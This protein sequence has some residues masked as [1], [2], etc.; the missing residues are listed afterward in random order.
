MFTAERVQSFDTTGICLYTHQF[1]HFFFHYLL[2]IINLFCERI[3]GRQVRIG[4]VNI[5]GI[6]GNFSGG[7]QSIA[8]LALISSCTRACRLW[9][10]WAL[11]SSLPQSLFKDTKA[12]LSL[13]QYSASLASAKYCCEENE[14]SSRDFLLAASSFSCLMSACISDIRW[15]TL[16]LSVCPNCLPSIMI[17]PWETILS[18]L[19]ERNLISSS[20]CSCLLIKI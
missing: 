2:D 14:S 18:I 13:I 16:W 11:A 5:F 4:V 9:S 7:G 19:G 17:S 8:L 12:I 3:G 10:A 1:C 15:T 20:S 6:G